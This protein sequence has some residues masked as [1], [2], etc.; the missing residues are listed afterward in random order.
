[1]QTSKGRL[2]WLEIVLRTPS[3]ATEITETVFSTSLQTRMSSLPGSQEMPRGP[4]PTFTV[5]MTWWNVAEVGLTSTNETESAVWFD[6]ARKSRLGPIAKSV[7]SGSAMRS[8]T[9]KRFEL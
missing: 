9:L 6:T 5:L 2:I 3:C 1:M 4:L 7:G 8:S